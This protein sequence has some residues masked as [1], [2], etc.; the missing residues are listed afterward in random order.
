MFASCYVPGNDSITFAITADFQFWMINTSTADINLA[1]CE[2][3]GVGLGSFSEVGIGQVIAVV[4]CSSA[5]N[6]F[7]RLDSCARCGA[8]LWGQVLGLE[9]GFRC[10]THG[11]C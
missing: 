11:F 1:A 7:L 4:E 2:I 10:G 6:Y 9:H 3:F 8:K 5:K